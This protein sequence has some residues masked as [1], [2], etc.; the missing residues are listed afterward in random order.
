MIWGAI[1]YK[2]MK[3]F[4]G[5]PDNMDS[6]KYCQMLG[7]SLLPYAAQALGENWTLMHEGASV[8]RSKYT[9]KWLEDREVNVLDWAAKSPDLNI[10]ENAWGLLA[11]RV[12]AD[13]KQYTNVRDLASAVVTE[14]TRKTRNK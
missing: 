4:D 13:G 1:S 6:R 5:V 11:R 10:I 12:Y 8:H 7:E 9:T 3:G 14:W 2:V